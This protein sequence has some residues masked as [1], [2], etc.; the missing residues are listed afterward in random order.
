[1]VVFNKVWDGTRHTVSPGAGVPF[2]AVIAFIDVSLSV[3]LAQGP[4]LVKGIFPAAQ[5][6]LGEQIPMCA[7]VGEGGSRDTGSVPSHSAW[8]GSSAHALP[9][10]GSLPPS[11]LGTP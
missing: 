10:P 2:L 11:L 3:E 8:L 6:K 7:Y 1:M 9:V 5:G 4:D